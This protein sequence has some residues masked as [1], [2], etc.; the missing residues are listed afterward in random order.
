MPGVIPDS[1]LREDLLQ[2][3]EVV[4][5][6]IE[7]YLESLREEPLPLPRW[8][9]ETIL[10]GFGTEVAEYML[11]I[12]AINF[13]YW[14]DPGR[15]P[16]GATLRGRWWPDALGLYG[17]FSRAVGRDPRWLRG[18]FL[19]G[20][21]RER[22]DEAFQGSAPLPMA[23]ERHRI[24]VEVGEGL[25][26]RWGDR[27]VHLLEEARGDAVR[28]VELLVTTLPPF[29]DVRELR[30]HSLAFHKRAQLAIAMIAGRFQRRGWGDLERLDQLTVFADYMLPRVLR[31]VGVLR[32]REDL[33]RAVDTETRIPEGDPEEVEIR[34][35]TLV[36]TERIVAGIRVGHP[37]LP[38][39]PDVDAVRLD[40]H[41]WR[42]GFARPGLAPFHRTRTTSY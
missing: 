7:E 42:Q 32:Y 27:F 2:A 29:S 3:V 26:Q 40:H 39:R 10:P 33:A 30:G 8:D 11:L 17:C 22:F 13:S 16:W 23:A 6:R 35:A 24:L 9:D 34:L 37:G 31:G 38:P 1:Q 15:R 41:L 18:D 20:L 25:H 36:A 28:A 5:A 4:P 14:E 19:A 21:T 12:N